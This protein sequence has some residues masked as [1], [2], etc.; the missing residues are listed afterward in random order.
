MRRP[1]VR[2]AAG[3][4]ASIL[5]PLMAVAGG[6]IWYAEVRERAAEAEIAVEQRATEAK[7]ELIEPL[8][9]EGA[10]VEEIFAAVEE[11]FGV[12]IEAGGAFLQNPERYTVKF[13]R[14]DSLDNILNVL[15][16]VI[17]GFEYTKTGNNITITN[18]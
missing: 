12:T 3:I 14:G 5:I 2:R 18:Q 15:Q 9:F 17:G 8:A 6:L 13:P 7:T 10:S 4:A 16:D 1:I 11:R